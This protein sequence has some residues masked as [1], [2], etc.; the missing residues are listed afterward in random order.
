MAGLE[1]VQAAQL[2]SIMDT[3]FLIRWRGDLQPGTHRVVFDGRTYDIEAVVE[4][5]RREG[6]QLDGLWTESPAAATA[7]RVRAGGL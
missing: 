2:M 7:G 4:L 6:L 1:R 5:G 3:R